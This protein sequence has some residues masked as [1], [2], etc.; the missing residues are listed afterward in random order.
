MRKLKDDVTRFFTEQV[1]ER[2]FQAPLTAFFKRARLVSPALDPSM[3][4]NSVLET[5]VGHSSNVA[6]VDLSKPAEGVSN[7]LLR[8]YA[9]DKPLIRDAESYE[10]KLFSVGGSEQAVAR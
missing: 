9:K 2:K 7:Y 1:S 3:P 8:E 5:L 4:L 6:A 10:C